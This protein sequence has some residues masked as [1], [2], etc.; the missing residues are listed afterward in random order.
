VR[1]ALAHSLYARGI[2][3]G[4]ERAVRDLAEGLTREGH[5]VA[6]IALAEREDERASAAG[7]EVRYLRLRNLYWPYPEA[8]AGPLAKALWHAV[9]TCNPAMAGAVGAALDELRPDVFHT[10]G[11]AGFSTLVWRAAKSRGLPV[12][13]TL[14]DHYVL[15]PRTTMF[16]HAKS[17]A[18]PCFECGLYAAPR[19]RMSALV[20]VVTG[21]SR[22][23]VERHRQ[24]GAFGAADARV[25]YNAYER[26]AAQPR[27]ARSSGAPLRFGY[28]GRL[29]P[30]KGV[31]R[32]IG[33]FQSLAQGAAE[34]WIAGSGAPAYEALLK[35]QAGE[36]QGIRWLGQAA[37]DA[38]L[39]EIDALVVPS[40]VHE[41]MARVVVEAFAF[42]RPVIGAKRGGIPELIDDTCGVLFDPG[43]EGELE[44]VLQRFVMQPQRLGPL[45]QGALAASAR[46][47]TKRSLAAYLDAYESAIARQ[48]AH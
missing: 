46:F 26:P 18:Q 9:D 39:A 20:D 10:H 30:I 40:L 37:P 8:D 44:R 31:E 11:V 22:Y 7:V 27:P 29:H 2:A 25:I 45:G 6:V 13:H 48:R 34:L 38:L 28:L 15:C 36:S 17:C 12:V 24:A 32:L 1:I 21:V 16:K 35:R 5:S 43:N 19:R 3:G 41:A 47:S 4:A 23:I 33:A 42:G 14:H